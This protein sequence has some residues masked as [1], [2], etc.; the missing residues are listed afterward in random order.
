MQKVTA[1]LSNT[2]MVELRDKFGSV[3]QENV[4]LSFYTTAHVGGKADALIPAN[5]ADELANTAAFLWEAQIPFILIGGGSN[6]L[7]SDE[8]YHGVILLNHARNI[9]IDT[10]TTPMVA[11][12]ESG[13][14]FGGLARQ[15][16]LRGMSGIEW[17]ANVPGSVGGAVYGNA[18]AFGS[19]TQASLTSVD[20]ILKDGGRQSWTAD[21][22]KYQYRSSILKREQ[23]S[24]V[25]LSASFKLTQSDEETVQKAIAASTEKRKSTQPP[26]ASTGSTF[27]NPEGDH[28]GRL[29]EAAG[30]KGYGIGGAVIS[31]IH[32]NFI[33]NQNNASAMD[34]Y[35]LIRHIQKTVADQFGVNL[36]LEIELV[37]HFTDGEF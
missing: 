29:I 1:P 20:L 34:Y 15:A 6:V 33:I 13:A 37:G 17:A 30:L 27:K 18:G 8:G 7:V 16:A 21:Q 31:P 9:R 36:E 28:A 22:M 4:S 14:N 3:L 2:Q 12:A 19:N 23:I 25:I 26:G 32:A 35:R 5:S 11:F 10:H 24:A